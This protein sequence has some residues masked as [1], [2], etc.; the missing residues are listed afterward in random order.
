MIM[1]PW[2]EVVIIA[3]IAGVIAWAAIGWIKLAKLFLD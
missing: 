1:E 3:F 2:S